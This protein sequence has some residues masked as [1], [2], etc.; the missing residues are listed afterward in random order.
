VQPL[1]KAL[2]FPTVHLPLV[3]TK[4][5]AVAPLVPAQLSATA[6]M[7]NIVLAFGA[8]FFAAVAFIDIMVSAF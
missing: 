5:L 1:P 4:A 3:D 6:F 2:H 8:L 7:V